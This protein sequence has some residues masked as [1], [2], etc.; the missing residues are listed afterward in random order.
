VNGARRDVSGPLEVDPAAAHEQVSGGTPSASVHHVRVGY[1]D[2]DRAGVVH[3]TVY[4]VYIEAARIAF[5]RERGLDYRAFEADT[6]LGLPVVGVQLRYRA[7][8]RFD[9]ELTV[10]TRVVSVSRAKVAFESVIRRGDVLLVEGV[11]EVA[12]AHLRE[13]RGCSIPD[14]IRQLCAS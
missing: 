1:V 6:G 2:T 13:E 10:S 8:A 14:V 12:C 4:L 11:V 7:P 5:F 3:H 9:D